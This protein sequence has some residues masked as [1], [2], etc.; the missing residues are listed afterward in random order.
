MIFVSRQS[1]A[2]IEPDSAF[3]YWR[4]TALECLAVAPVEDVGQFS[5]QRLRVVTSLGT[6]F[7]T[8]SSPIVVERQIQ[9]I[10]RDGSND[11]SL[12]LVLGGRGHH[13]QGNRGGVVERGG[14]GIVTL[15]RP[16]IS[17]ASET[18][19]EMRLH[20][21]RSTFLAHVGSPKE[22]AGRTFTGSGLSELLAVYLRSF[23]GSVERMSAAEAAHA[24]E[25]AL[26]LVRGVV[27]LGATVPSQDLS[28]TAVRS[29]VLAYMQRRLHDP[30]L[31]PAAISAALRIS[32]TRI[33]IAFAPNGGV[34]AAIRDAR[35]DLV[36]RRLGSQA[37][38]GEPIASIA[39][40]SGFR[41]GGV[42]SRAFRRRYGLSARAFRHLSRTV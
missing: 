38:D 8:H 27:N 9:D 22:V 15:D 39:R 37:W 2:G 19:E 14:I 35:L 31:D 30:S 32:R 33:Y 11:V 3:D 21:S 40:A 24:F 7:H 16:F 34:A 6:L 41:D 18:Y 26:Y 17:G 20:I 36:L 29:L 28:K 4:S 25:G 23:A 42:F 12:S 10:R 13:E 5:A 1:T